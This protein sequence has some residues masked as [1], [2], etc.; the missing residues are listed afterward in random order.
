MDK[1][2]IYKYWYGGIESIKNGD[3]ENLQLLANTS[4]P[5][6]EKSII[7]EPKFL[8]IYQDWKMKPD[9]ADEK[10]IMNGLEMKMKLI[11]SRIMKEAGRKELYHNLIH[12]GYDDSCMDKNF[13][14]TMLGNRS[15]RIAV[16]PYVNLPDFYLKGKEDILM[17]AKKI[18]ESFPF[19]SYKKPEDRARISK[20][21]EDTCTLVKKAM[22]S[23]GLTLEEHLLLKVLKFISEDLKVYE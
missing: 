5:K 22:D 14:R 21:V 12:V 18:N 10:E 2:T 17:S 16:S 20:S 19:E 23:F 1:I 4:V 3:F 9:N 11:E 13:V 7:I 8:G 15:E 6:T